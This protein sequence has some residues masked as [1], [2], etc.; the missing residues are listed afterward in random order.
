MKTYERV[1]VPVC[2]SQRTILRTTSHR[3]FM[4]PVT[5]D[6]NLVL[7]QLGSRA[8]S[9]PR[10][11]EKTTIRIMNYHGRKEH[12]ARHGNRLVILKLWQTEWGFQKI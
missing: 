3:T 4:V 2:V 7:P 5:L 11:K 8:R 10:S 12:N 9:E 1:F 6:M